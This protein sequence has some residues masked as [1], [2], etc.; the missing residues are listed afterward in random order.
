MY[1]EIFHN[2]NFIKDTKLQVFYFKL[3]VKLVIRNK[4][5]NS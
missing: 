2:L 5:F 4:L 3:F 1:L